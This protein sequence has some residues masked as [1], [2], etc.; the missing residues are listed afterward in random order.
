MGIKREAALEMLKAA[1]LPVAEVTKLLEKAL[2]PDYWH[3]LNPECGVEAA[4]V[5]WDDSLDPGTIASAAEQFADEGYFAVEPVLPA[6]LIERMRRCVDV[7]RSAN[8]PPVFTFIYDDFWNIIRTK[9]FGQLLEALLGRDYRQNSV[10]WTYYVSPVR[11]CAGWRPHSDGNG[12]YRLTVWIPLSDATVQNGCIYVIPR[13]L[14]PSTLPAKFR[15]WESV[16][17]RQLVGLLQ[18]SRA[19]PAKPGAI[20]GWDH[21]VIHWGSFSRGNVAARVNIGL[22]FLGAAAQPN[23]WEG[24]MID[25]VTLPNFSLRLYTIGKRILEYGKFEPKMRL[26]ADFGRELM[27]RTRF[28]VEAL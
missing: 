1:R 8:W 19:L 11:R 9:S 21:D 3:R 15:E 25:R 16:N 2:D 13:D 7:V 4:S 23:G 17:K 14:M 20:L 28:Q 5:A 22:E 10:V 26:Y 27:S 12:D 18:A 6:A 24:P